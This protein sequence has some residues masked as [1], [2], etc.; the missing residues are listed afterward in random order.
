MKKNDKI[1]VAGHRGLVGSAVVQKLKNEGY[2][3]LILKTR[4][5][6][7]LINQAAV[8]AFFQNERPDYVILAAAHVG[9]ILAN[10]TYQ[11]NFLYD[12]LMIQSNVIWNAHQYGVKKLLFLGSSCIYP[13]DCPQPIR[14]EYLLGGKLESTN[15]GYAIAKIA[16]MK[17][18]EKIYEQYSKQF[19][20]CM[21]TNV[22]G[23]ND[24]FH[25]EHSHVIPGLIQKIHAAMIE[26]KP[27]V[28]LW[29]NG[30]VKREFLY[31]DDLA[32]AIYFI[33]Q[34]YE[35]KLFL[36]V[37]TGEEITI[38]EVAHLIAELLGYKGALIFDKTHPDGT[39]R[40]LLDLTR[41][42]ALGWKHKI[43]LKEG[44]GKVI[45]YYITYGANARFS[46]TEW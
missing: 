37:G 33:M 17:L 4:N 31:A 15:E 8:A 41:L 39:P 25:P 21:P 7:D 45:D 24:N 16:G 26:N 1:F 2:D 40:K 3:N 46:I 14:E 23:T 34:Y 11:A 6:L 35:D 28:K 42:H 29:G 18:C 20:S 36:N 12:N 22:Y 19:I 10:L 5:E 43:S 27:E 38:K 30:M 32:D 44:L 13:R 9:G